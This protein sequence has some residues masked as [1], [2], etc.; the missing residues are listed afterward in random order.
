MDKERIC[1]NCKK[2]KDKK[3]SVTDKFVARKKTCDADQFAGK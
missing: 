1:K 3:C 2:R